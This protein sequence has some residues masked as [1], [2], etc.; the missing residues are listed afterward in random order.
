PIE[1][2]E[3]LGSSPGNELALIYQLMTMCRPKGEKVA[4][5]QAAK[6]EIQYAT[7]LEQAERWHD[8]TAVGGALLQLI[9]RERHPQDWTQLAALY[10]G[11]LRMSDKKE[12]SLVYLRV[13]LEAREGQFTDIDKAEIWLDIALAD[14]HDDPAAAAV[15][16]KE[17]QRF[18]KEDSPMSMQ[19]ESLIAR[20]ELSGKGLTD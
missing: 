2:K 3:Y 9:D 8:L 19:A 11:A 4:L 16:A 18:C 12:D 17:C 5:T 7:Y 13:A 10:G 1:Q 20:A 14:S 15:A 6:L